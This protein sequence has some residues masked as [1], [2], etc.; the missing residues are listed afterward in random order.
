MP[1]LT[2]TRRHRISSARFAPP[3]EACLNSEERS[4]TSELVKAF[5]RCLIDRR[6]PEKVRHTLEDLAGQRVFGIACGHP[7][8]NDSDRLAD[9]PIHKLLLGRDPGAGGRLAS[10]PTVSRFENGAGRVAPPP[11]PPATPGDKR[12]PSLN[13]QGSASRPIRRP[14]AIPRGGQAGRTPARGARGLCPQRL[15]IGSFRQPAFA[16]P[17]QPEN[18]RKHGTDP[19]RRPVGLRGC[20]RRLCRIGGERGTVP[21][22]YAAG[23]AGKPRPSWRLRNRA[24]NRRASPAKPAFSQYTTPD[25]RAGACSPARPSLGLAGR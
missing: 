20:G 1:T 2:I 15:I 17:P 13:D 16:P 18:A 8:G 10:Q 12:P 24:V 22:I 11:L 4:R 21:D 5:G 3:S 19:R 23:F 7:D 25:R 14:S 9:D 6:A